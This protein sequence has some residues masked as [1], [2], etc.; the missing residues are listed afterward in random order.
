MSNDPLCQMASPLNGKYMFNLAEMTAA[1]KQIMLETAVLHK[2]GEAA[3]RIFRLLLR[4]GFKGGCVTTDRLPLKLELK[5][6]AEMS[7][8]PE[9]E[10]RPLLGRMLAAGFVSLQ[11]MPRS[12]DHNPRTTVYLWHV[13][14]ARACRALEAEMLATESKLISRL[15]A[16][17]RRGER[18]H[19]DGESTAPSG[20]PSRV[21][22][23]LETA[24]LQTHES[25]MFFRYI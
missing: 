24:I 19:G 1:V 10:A 5:Q 4:L 11:E 6:V 15:E 9:R 14:M 25:I 13:E 20:D 2:F 3:C 21:A 18:M 23:F 16:E 7:L 12:T 8:M 17:H 22:S